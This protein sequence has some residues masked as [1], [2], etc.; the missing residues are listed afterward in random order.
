MFEKIKK[1]FGFGAMRLP[2]IGENVDLVMDAG[3]NYFDTAHP[4]L[5]GQ[6]EIALRE[7]LVKRYDRESFVLTNKLSPSQFQTREEI[8]PLFQRQLEAC[9]VD[10]FDFY[11]LHAMDAEYFQK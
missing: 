7:C 2:M 11:L 3:F 8:R 9:G 5:K 6:S 4:Y 10:Y 1:N